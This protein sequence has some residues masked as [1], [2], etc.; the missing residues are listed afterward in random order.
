[1]VKNL[2]SERDITIIIPTLNEEDNIGLLLDKLTKLYKNVKIL[3]VDDGSKDNTRR[4]VREKMKGNRNIALLDRSILNKKKGLTYSILDGIEKTNTKYFVV[5]DADF[6][7][8]PEV[9]KKFIALIKNY[10]LLVGNRKK[11]EDWSMIRLMISRLSTMLVI[12]R[13][14][15]GNNPIPKDPLSGLFASRRDL[16]LRVYKKNKRKFIGEGYKVL[17]D[18]LK[19]IKKRDI[20]IYNI[21]YTF[22]KRKYGI[23]KAKTSTMIDLIKSIIR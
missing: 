5:M 20:S 19:C 21:D 8:P 2:K 16:F 12:F 14:F 7:H 18:F 4:I 13:L 10:D 15:I 11:I 3:V 17:F 23:S 1:M 22:H 6:Q 9:I